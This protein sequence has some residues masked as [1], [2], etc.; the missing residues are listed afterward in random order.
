[1]ID[2]MLNSFHHHNSIIHHNTDCQYKRK[3]RECVDGKSKWD[4]KYKCSDQ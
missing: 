1:M 3:Q 2:I 4:E